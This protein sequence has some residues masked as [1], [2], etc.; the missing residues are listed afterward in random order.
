MFRKLADELLRRSE[1]PVPPRMLE[2]YLDK[3]ADQ[4]VHSSHGKHDDDAIRKFKEEYRTAGIWNL[5]WYLLRNQ[6]IRAFD[7]RVTKEDLEQE[8]GRMA[9]IED[10]F[11]DDFKKKLT[12]AQKMQIHD[13]LQ[14]RK[15]LNHLE[16]KVQIQRASLSLAQFE[17]RAGQSSLITL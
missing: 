7:L 2:D 12:D 13:D 9:T 4:A 8:Y 11:A 14:E 16:S 17:G 15:V 5:R 10:E 3:M 6:I 1:F